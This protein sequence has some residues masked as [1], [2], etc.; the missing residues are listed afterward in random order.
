MK[1]GDQLAI[2]AERK[3]DKVS[4]S[5]AMA[6]VAKDS[7]PPQGQPAWEA[8]GLELKPIAVDEFR[9]NTRHD[10]AAGCWSR[11]CGPTA[12]RRQNIRP[13]DVLVGMH[14]WETISLENVSYILNRPDLN[15]VSPVK[16]FILRGS[17]TL[18][19]F[20]NVSASPV[21]MKKTTRE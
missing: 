16:F 3:H 9:Q 15:T 8:L 10:S 6:E 17:E 7:T 19:G 1:V 13:G 11:R 20:F 2:V 14:I 18:Y 12:R 21:A 5:L 4:V